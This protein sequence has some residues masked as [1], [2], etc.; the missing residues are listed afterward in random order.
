MNNNQ[1]AAF[2]EPIKALI[3]DDAPIMRKAIQQIVGKSDQIQV[4][5]T[6]ANG[7]ECL[8][9]IVELQPDVITLDIDMPVMN[10]ITALKNI[11]VRHQ[12][13][14]V[15]ISSL[16]RDG[17]FA[18]EALRLGVVDFIPKPSR[19]SGADWE[20][21]ENLVRMRVLLASGM[22]VKRMR[23]VRRRKLAQSHFNSSRSLPA[24]VVLMGTNLA[25]PNAIMHII[26]SLPRDFAGA[27]IAVQEIHPQILSPFCSYFNSISPL[28][29][30]PVSDGCRLLAGRV[31]VGSSFTGINVVT[32]PG[33][34][35][36]L[37]VSDSPVSP[38][39]TLFESAA[40]SF[41]D[42]S[43]GVLMTGVGSD[44]TEGL[45]KIKARGG[46]TIGQKQEC[47]AYPN[48]VQHAF[49]ENVLD[50]VL[51]RRGIVTQLQ[52]WMRQRRVH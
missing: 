51:P 22:Q 5:G 39:D 47:C 40:H 26:T 19:T 42:N 38:I 50:K 31:Y 11:M 23:R 34:G 30:H 10:G 15:I 2:P 24:A 1:A 25:G 29:V 14:V 7:Q 32:A 28:E 13:P 36:A 17:Y 3:V 52:E 49:D 16:V 45:R 12:K 37:R 21:E 43:C 41:K 35:Y 9:K 27:V 46:F 48:L 33:G 20:K 44:G 8:N 4:I 18:F 6:A